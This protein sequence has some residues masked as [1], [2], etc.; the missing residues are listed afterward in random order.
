M[1]SLRQ[2]VRN[3]T[4][5]AMFRNMSLRALR[6]TVSITIMNNHLL[7]KE[8]QYVKYYN[9]KYAEE[10]SYIQRVAVF[11][12]SVFQVKDLFWSPDSEILTVVCEQL[13][14]DNTELQLWT[15]NNCTWYLKQVMVF[16]KDDPLI[17]AVWSARMSNKSY[18]KELILLTL[19][20]LAYYLFTWRVN[21]NKCVTTS[22]KALIGVIQGQK[23]LL[24]DFKTAIV[25]PPWGQTHVLLKES[26]NAIVFAPNG[27]R[28]QVD[29]SREGTSWMDSSAFCT[30]S[31]SNMLTFFKKVSVS[32]TRSIKLTLN[33]YK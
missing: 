4:I 25:P 29:S 19:R 27:K 6:R 16:N 21:H 8:L 24:T 26:V 5:T 3:T 23:V 14:T 15:E 22:D 17:H 30:V 32:I 10:V 1:N 31:C 33:K 28:Q 7:D 2:P 20:G 9:I 13:D 18:K 12:I 11:F